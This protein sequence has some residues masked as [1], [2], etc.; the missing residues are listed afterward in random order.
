MK[1]LYKSLM[2]GLFVLFLMPFVSAQYCGGD[3]NTICNN[4]TFTNSALTTQTDNSIFLFF[5]IAIGVLLLAAGFYVMNPALEA[6][7]GIW[8]LINGT[9]LIVDTNY[10]TAIFYFL[11][12]VSIIFHTIIN[13]R[14]SKNK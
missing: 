9:T 10:A 11:I 4:V 1:I 12:G 6:A 8:F 2:L 3:N 14:E 13:L 7:A 5:T